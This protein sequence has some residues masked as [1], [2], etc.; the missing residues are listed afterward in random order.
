MTAHVQ[1]R[2]YR[3]PEVTLMFPHYD[4]S[5]DM[6]SVGVVIA[7]LFR[8]CCSSGGPSSGGSNYQC[9]FES[10][11]GFPLSANTEELDKDGYPKTQGHILESILAK[12]GTVNETDTMF[13]KDQHSL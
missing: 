3:A 5:V 2:A 7:E 12:I 8:V 9:F 11:N 6:W 10:T 13:L 1:T 4:Q